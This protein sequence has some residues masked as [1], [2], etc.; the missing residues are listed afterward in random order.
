LEYNHPVL[1]SSYTEK[2]YPLAEDADFFVSPEGSD[3][4]SGTRSDPFATFARAAE[5]ARSVPK[6]AEK[7]S[8]TV[9]FFAGDYPHSV[10]ELTAEDAG[11]EECPVVYCAYGDGVARFIGG[12][13]VSPDEFVPLEDEDRAYIRDKVFGKV[14]KADLSGKPLS[15][16]LSYSSETFTESYGRLNAGR[17][18]N[19]TSEGDEIY[20]EGVLKSPSRG[21]LEIGF[22]KNRFSNYHTFEGMQLVGCFGDEYWKT[23]FPVTGYDGE[24]GVLSYD[25]IGPQYGLYEYVPSVYFLNVSEEVDSPN[26]SWIDPVNKTLYVYDPSD[27]EYIVSSTESFGVINGA[28]HI[29]FVGLT[30]EGCTGDGFNISA[31]DVTFDRC[32]IRGIGGRAGIRCYGVDFRMQD[33]EFAYT[34][35]CGMWFDCNKPV[36]DLVPTGPY[37]DNCLIH[38]MG[39]KWKNLQNPGIRIKCAVGATVSHCEIYNTPCAALT[40]GYCAEGGSERAID[41]L[42]EYNYIHDVDQDVVD[43]GCIYCGRSFV[44]RDNVFRY[45]LIS[46]I[47]GG[48]GRFAIYLDDGLAAQTIYGNIFYNFTDYAILHSGGQYMNIHDNAYIVTGPTEHIG[49][50]SWAKYYGFR[51]DTDAEYPTAWNSGNF[52]ILYKTLE[53]RPM[54]GGYAEEYYDLWHSRWPELYDIIDDYDDVENPNC[55]ATPGFCSLYNN[56]AIGNSKIHIDEAVEKFALRC[57]NNLDFTL[58]DNP[59]FVNPTLG[60]YRTRDDVG[61]FMQI[62]F[63]RIGR[64]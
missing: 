43:I 34:A 16:L 29:K 18:P 40:F 49:L 9:A 22:L 21:K 41:C 62:P 64:Y 13:T 46:D 7:G 44:N 39:Q 15:E 36:E 57:E 17:Y 10:F 45:N 4:G 61:D 48:G 8:V 3:S 30:F 19:R 2:E 20:I 63:D 53:M 6:T 55:P 5:A 56:Y 54:K 47:P 27:E 1:M 32:T 28:D 51:Y 25:I 38:D 42:F 59:L 37:I 58:E 35:G 12:M 50:N 31:N 52:R 33:C 26:E 23:V 11:I 24:T 14:K 60:D